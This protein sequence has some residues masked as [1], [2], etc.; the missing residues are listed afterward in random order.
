MNSAAKVVMKVMEG[1]CDGCP[2]DQTHGSGGHIAGVC[3]EG[4]SFYLWPGVLKGAAFKLFVIFLHC[5]VLKGGAIIA[6]GL[7][8]SSVFPVDSATGAF[9]HILTTVQYFSHGACQPSKAGACLFVWK[10]SDLFFHL[11]DL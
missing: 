4:H 9:D 5:M 7:Q 2:D 11:E 6:Y 1:V 10:E 3:L 8:M